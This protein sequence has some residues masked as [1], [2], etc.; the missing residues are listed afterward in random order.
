MF[1]GNSVNMRNV[2]DFFSTRFDMR[3]LPKG[4]TLR[5]VNK[6]YCFDIGFDEQFSCTESVINDSVELDDSMKSILFEVLNKNNLYKLFVESISSQADSLLSQLDEQDELTPTEVENTVADKQNSLRH[7]TWRFFS[8]EDSPIGVDA[9]IY[10]SSKIVRQEELTGEMFRIVR[11]YYRTKDIEIPHKERMSIWTLKNFLDSDILES[12]EAE[13]RLK[14]SPSFVKALER[15][16][17]WVD[18]AWNKIV[19]SNVTAMT[20]YPA[21]WLEEEDFFK[22][23]DEFFLRIKQE[24]TAISAMN[25]EFDKEANANAVVDRNSEVFK[26]DIGKIVLAK[27]NSDKAS[28]I[29]KVLSESLKEMKE[30]KPEK[31]RLTT[32]LKEVK[33]IEEFCSDAIN[34]LVFEFR[35]QIYNPEADDK[36]QMEAEADAAM[37]EI[38]N[39]WC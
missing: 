32:L 4:V 13:L 33:A 9:Y 23:E 7:K 3:S 31:S 21:E 20:E 38:I 35:N 5:V 8:N 1:E 6:F 29:L 27:T 37:E 11:D 30:S 36:A 24:V 18:S 28:E 34:K 39:S 22:E 19:A 2:Y 17:H 14:A 26:S 15:V 10:M 25:K 12:A 16:R